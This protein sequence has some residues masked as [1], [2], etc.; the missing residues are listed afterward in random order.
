VRY[1]GV[2]SPLTQPRTYVGLGFVRVGYLVTGGS[3]ATLDARV[4]DVSPEGEALLVTRGSY[5]IDGNGTVAGYD[6]LPAG[7]IDLPLF[8]NQWTLEK[9][10]RLRLDLT[11]VDYPTF[12]PAN[13]QGDPTEPHVSFPGAQLVLPT[14]EATELTMPGA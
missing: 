4:W 9:G 12:L 1:T 11:E 14:R 5:R 8:G 2:S 6:P 10:H 7:T 3:T 13:A